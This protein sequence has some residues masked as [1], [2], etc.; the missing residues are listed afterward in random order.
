M[1]DVVCCKSFTYH[2]SFKICNPIKSL[3]TY[4][5]GTMSSANMYTFHIQRSENTG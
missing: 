1:P 4:K 2:N 3:Q 5:I